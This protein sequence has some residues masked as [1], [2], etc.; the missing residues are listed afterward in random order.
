MKLQW[1]TI[2]VGIRRNLE[3]SLLEKG[4][5]FP[6]SVLCGFVVG[7]VRMNY[8]WDENEEVKKMV[9]NGINRWYGDKNRIVA[10]HGHGISNL[11]YSFGAMKM[12]WMDIPKEIKECFYNCIEKNSSRFISLEVSSILYG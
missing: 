3:Q 2:P 11:I 10:D 1:E 9:Y 7:S 6:I 5:E 8:R 4:K 12:N